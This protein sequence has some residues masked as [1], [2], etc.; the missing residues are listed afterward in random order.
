MQHLPLQIRTEAMSLDRPA[1]DTRFTLTDYL[2]ANYASRRPGKN[3]QAAR[4]GPPRLL[5][6]PPRKKVRDDRMRRPGHYVPSPCD[7]PRR[8][9]PTVTDF[10]EVARLIDIAALA[11]GDVVG[12]QLKA[13]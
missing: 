7:A 4:W 13:R 9:L 5:L 12:Q 1:V 3:T 11:H 10:G 6:R 2:E 8:R